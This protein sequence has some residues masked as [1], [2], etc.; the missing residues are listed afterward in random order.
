MSDNILLI[1]ITEAN[2]A[3]EEYDGTD[4]EGRLRAAMKATKDHWAL[5]DENEQIR[6]AVIATCAVYG[7]DSDETKRLAAEWDNLT[8]IGHIIISGMFPDTVKIIENP[9]GIMKLWKEI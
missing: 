4:I 2:S 8:D 5:T 3:I 9:V 1:A 7:K 6:A